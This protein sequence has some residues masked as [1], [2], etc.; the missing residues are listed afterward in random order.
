MSDHTANRFT[1][2]DRAAI[3]ATIRA[4][5]DRWGRAVV[6]EPRRDLAF[7]LTRLGAHAIGTTLFDLR[8][9]EAEEISS[10]ACAALDERITNLRRADLIG[11]R[12]ECG[13]PY[14]VNLRGYRCAR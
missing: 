14:D 10:E 4:T 3:R 6:T 9:A 11:T 1:E 7:T 13:A 12:C 8:D 2:A 5:L